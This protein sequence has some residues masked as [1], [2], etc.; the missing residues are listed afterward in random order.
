MSDKDNSRINALE[1]FL[2]DF[3]VCQQTAW[4]E[5][6]HGKGA[7]EAMKWIESSL[8]C[9]EQLPDKNMS[10]YYKDGRAIIF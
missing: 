8:V 6:K 9:P 1:V 2:Q 10:K 4:I 3:V 5:W 7:E